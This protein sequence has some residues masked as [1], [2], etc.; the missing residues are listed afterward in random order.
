MTRGI[1]AFTMA[2]LVPITAAAQ[3]P[4]G[5]AAP[6]TQGPMIVERVHS[7][8]VVAP[9]FKITEVDR[10]TSGL[11]GGYAGW[12]TDDTFFI[13]GG[14]YW[15]ANQ[16][17]DRKM[18][19]GGLV[20]QWLAL[21]DRRVGFSAKGLVGGGRATLGATIPRFSVVPGTTNAPGRGPTG[22]DMD[23]DRFGQSGSIANTRVRYGRNFFVVEPEADVVFTLTRRLHLTAGAGYRFTGIDGRRGGDN[24]RL[25]GAVGSVALQIGTGS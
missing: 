24:D 7:G 17:S 22:F 11:A 16:V 19:Y 13:G 14:G 5:T 2:C 25:R 15:L 18:A 4:G 23:M 20:L 12:V 3:T 6:Q 9:D 8:F 21:N 1:F 10:E